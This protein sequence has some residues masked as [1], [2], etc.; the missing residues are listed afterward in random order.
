MDS[1]ASPQLCTR[2]SERSAER[3]WSYSY[4]LL[5]RGVSPRTGRVESRPLGTERVA[6]CARC[7]RHILR[8]SIGALLGETPSA[9][10]F[11]LFSLG[12]FLYGVYS[13]EAVV[14]YG[15]VLIAAGLWALAVFVMRRPKAMRRGAFLLRRKELAAFHRVAVGELQLYP[16]TAV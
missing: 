8:A 13:A 9:L 11:N 12:T 7:E 16:D 10:A 2:C 15:A 5:R 6:L 3:R 14:G 4:G 1:T